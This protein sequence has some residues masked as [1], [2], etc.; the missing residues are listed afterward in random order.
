M[1]PTL[2]ALAA[3]AVIAAGAVWLTHQRKTR[4]LKAAHATGRVDAR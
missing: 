1:K 2:L 3:A 4:R